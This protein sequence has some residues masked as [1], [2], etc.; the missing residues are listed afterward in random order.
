MTSSYTA[1][2]LPNYTFRNVNVTWNIDGGS[3]IT[4]LNACASLADANPNS[5]R[6][7]STDTNTSQYNTDVWL[8]Q[9][10]CDCAT[11]GRCIKK[12][13]QEEKPKVQKFETKSSPS[14]RRLARYIS[15]A[16]E[17]CNERPLA[18]PYLTMRQ[19]IRVG[20]SRWKSDLKNE[21]CDLESINPNHRIAQGLLDASLED[22]S[23]KHNPVM[24]DK[25]KWEMPIKMSP[26][27]MLEDVFYEIFPQ[28]KS[29]SQR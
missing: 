4:T 22:Y 27:Q 17:A 7:N 25:K 2:S 16:E 11:Q 23:G 9:P 13:C 29:E 28:E 15:E 19:F 24:A 8:A 5:L 18:N 12:E 20:L 10:D 1:T 21:D 3:S 6:K 14:K 26:Q